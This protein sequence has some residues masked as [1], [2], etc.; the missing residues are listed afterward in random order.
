MSSTGYKLRGDLVPLNIADGG[1][2][3]GTALNND[4]IVGSSAGAIVELAALTNGQVFLGSTGAAPVAAS[5]TAGSGISVTPGAGSLTIAATGGTGTVTSVSVVSANGLAGTVATPSTTPAI[6]LSTTVTGILSG[7]GTAIS[8]ASTT[9]TGSVV[10]QTSPS[11]ITPALGTPSSG[12]LTNATGLPLTTGVTGVLPIANGGTNSSTALSNNRLMQSSAGTIIEA[13]ALTNGQLFIGSTGATPVAASLTAGTGITITPGAGTITIATSGASGVTGSGVATRVAYWDTASSISSDSALFWD[14]TNDRL[15]IGTITPDFNLDIEFNVT[16]GVVGTYPGIK[17]ENT[18]STAGS[19]FADATWRV[20]NRNVG[21]FIDV[22]IVVAGTDTGDG[23]GNPFLD[24]IKGGAIGTFTANPFLIT[25]NDIVRGYF[26]TSGRFGL[27]NSSTAPAFALDIHFDSAAADGLVMRNNNANAD[28]IVGFNDGATREWTIGVDD[29]DSS[30]FK[31]GQAAITTDVGLTISGGITPMVGVRTE[32]P[33]FPLDISF[34]STSFI[35]GVFPS[36]KV[37]NTQTAG[38]SLAFFSEVLLRTI[39]DTTGTTNVDVKFV[40]AGTNTGTGAPNPFLDGVRG[41]GV[42]TSTPHPFMITTNEIVRGYFDTSGHF[43]LGYGSTAPVFTLDIQFDTATAD[44]LVM[45]NNNANADI[46]VGFNDGVTREW[47]IGVDDSD[48]NKFKFGQAAI[49]TEVAVTIT[50]GSTPNVGIRTESPTFPLDISFDSPSF[51]DGVFPS[52]KVENTRTSG[53]SLAF[54]SEV[55][56]R[57]TDDSTGTTKV[58]VKFV[59]S[60]TNTGTG[61]P[62]PFL[63]GVR[64]GGVGTST[65]HPFMIVTNEIVRFYTDTSGHFAFNYGST[66]PTFTL[67]VQFDTATADGLVMRNNNAN[68]DIIVGYNDS[69]TR[70]WTV[71]VDDVD[72]TGANKFKFGQSALTT[73][74]AVTITSGST[75]NIGIRT[76]DPTFP[77]DISFD[78]G[79][80]TDGL[81]P[82]IKIE[83]IR[84]SGG[85]IPFF[86]ELLL[87]TT[88]DSTGTTKV[89][90]KLVDSGTNTGTGAPNP[91]LD[92]IRGGGVGTSTAHPFMLVTSEAVRMLIESDGD[93]GMGTTTPSGQLHIDQSSTTGAQPVLYVNQADVSEEFIRFQ[94]TAAVSNITQ[95]IVAVASVTTATTAGYLKVFV[96]DDGNQITDQA[97]FIAIETLT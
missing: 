60:G 14:P 6:T 54:F 39:D 8:A 16:S 3:A 74:V 75:P 28:V 69:G 34:A 90:V 40:N 25:T 73:D 13:A 96:V 89:D 83:N 46:I 62:N 11:L 21:G 93:I 65:T 38:G 87:R 67:D 64:G 10:L 76:E 61:A 29:S 63:D 66:A 59:N 82:G 35:D 80:S 45:R 95:S 70:E 55:L 77:L 86:S 57:T 84:T 81:F 4:R 58:D 36:I 42:G 43:A 78:S 33:T 97:Y 94:G 52:I 12:V 23:G 19:Q 9:G 24:G 2:N 32:S 53:G 56:L 50:S 49:T 92:G 18:N 79:S 85:S 88:D 5:I 51:T 26:D 17:V 7:N 71:G 30:K 41:G 68:A 27:G 22:K 1:T 72:G 37:E 20:A 47:T 91:F 48:S 31:F 44:G 15:G